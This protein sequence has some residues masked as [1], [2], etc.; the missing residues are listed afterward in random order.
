MG[1]YTE[2]KQQKQIVC[3][4]KEPTI[5]F[6]MPFFAFIIGAAATLYS[7]FIL[8]PLAKDKLKERRTKK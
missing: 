8:Y 5:N 1:G 2:L 6:W 4:Y 7:I 3:E